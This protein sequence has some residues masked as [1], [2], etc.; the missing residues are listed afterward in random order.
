MVHAQLDEEGRVSKRSMLTNL[1]NM[2]G[3][4]EPWVEALH[5][6]GYVDVDTE[7]LKP[8]FEYL[9]FCLKQVVADNELGRCCSV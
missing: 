6:A 9:Q 1:F 8:L 7:Q 3:K 5:T 2:G 4:K